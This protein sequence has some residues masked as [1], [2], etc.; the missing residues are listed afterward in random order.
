M[1]W[2]YFGRAGPAARSWLRGRNLGGEPARRAATRGFVTAGFVTPG[3]VTRG[4]ATRGFVSPGCVPPGFV[5]RGSV[6]S[7]PLRVGGGGAPAQPWVCTQTPPAHHA[8]RLLPIRP[9]A[10]ARLRRRD[11]LP[12][13]RGPHLVRRPL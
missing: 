12:A 4:V 13:R 1:G 3:F 2:V 7:V 11:H 5:T 8:S 9:V 10:G 6:G